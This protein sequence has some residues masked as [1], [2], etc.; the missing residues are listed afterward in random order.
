MRK[1]SISIFFLHIISIHL[2]LSTCLFSLAPLSPLR[3]DKDQKKQSSPKEQVSLKK[4]SPET[5]VESSTNWNHY[6]EELKASKSTKELQSFWSK[7]IAENNLKNLLENFIHTQTMDN[8]LD[9][10]FDSALNKIKILNLTLDYLFSSSIDKEYHEQI[11]ETISNS[12]ITLLDICKESYEARNYLSATQ[13]ALQYQKDI[14]EIYLKF[15]F[16]SKRPMTLLTDK[17]NELLRDFDQKAIDFL[18][19]KRTETFIQNLAENHSPKFIEEYMEIFSFL[20]YPYMTKK[21]RKS[22]KDKIILFDKLLINIFLKNPNASITLKS[23][24]TDKLSFIAQRYSQSKENQSTKQQKDKQGD[25]DRS[26]FDESIWS[27]L[28]SSYKSTDFL[29]TK[30]WSERDAFFSCVSHLERADFH[31]KEKPIANLQKPSL[32]TYSLKDLKELFDTRMCLSL[33]RSLLDR[34]A[35]PTIDDKKDISLWLKKIGTLQSLSDIINDQSTEAFTD[36]VQPS[37]TPNEKTEA[38]EIIQQSMSELSEYKSFYTSDPN[39]HSIETLLQAEEKISPAMFSFT[40][41]SD[42]ETDGEDIAKTSLSIENWLKVVLSSLE[43]IQNSS[44]THINNADRSSYFVLYNYLKNHDKFVTQE[45]P[46]SRLEDFYRIWTTTQTL[47]KSQKEA[48]KQKATGLKFLSKSSVEK[49]LK[50]MESNMIKTLEFFPVENTSTW[51]SFLN[52]N[53]LLQEKENVSENLKRAFRLK[54]KRML[55][56]SKNVLSS[57]LKKDLP[58]LLLAPKTDGSSITTALFFVQKCLSNQK[59]DI[60]RYLS[61]GLRESYQQGGW[62]NIYNLYLFKK[63]DLLLNPEERERL[64]IILTTISEIFYREAFPV[65]LESKTPI[66]FSP[67]LNVNDLLAS[68]D[69]LKQFFSLKNSEVEF[70]ALNLMYQFNSK[71]ALSLIIT[72]LVYYKEYIEKEEADFLKGKR[73]FTNKSFERHLE[74][75]FIFMVTIRKNAA[76]RK[77]FSRSDSLSQTLDINIG[78]LQKR[79][80]SIFSNSYFT[81]TQNERSYEE[82]ESRDENIPLFSAQ[83]FNDLYNDMIEFIQSIE[84][85]NNPNIYDILIVLDRQKYFQQILNHWQRDIF[86]S[87]NKDLLDRKKILDA[88]IQSMIKRYKNSLRRKNA[89]DSVSVIDKLGL[90]VDLENFNSSLNDANIALKIFLDTLNKRKT[91]SQNKLREYLNENF[92]IT[93][94]PIIKDSIEQDLSGTRIRWDQRSL[95][96]ETLTLLSKMYDE[97]N[98]TESVTEDSLTIEELLSDQN[99]FDSLNLEVLE[100]TLE[101]FLDIQKE[102]IPTVDSVDKTLANFYK[103]FEKINALDKN[104]ITPIDK[105][106]ALRILIDQR[107]RYIDSII[108]RIDQPLNIEGFLQNKWEQLDSLEFESLSSPLSDSSRM[109]HF[110]QETTI[111]DYFM[112]ST[113]YDPLA[114]QQGP[115]SINK[116]LT[117]SSSIHAF[118]SN[119][120]NVTYKISMIKLLALILNNIQ[121]LNLSPLSPN[122]TLPLIKS[123]A[124]TNLSAYMYKLNKDLENLQQ[125][126]SKL[127]TEDMPKVWQILSEISSVKNLFENITDS[128][129]VSTLDK[130]FKS[131]H[132]TLISQMKKQSTRSLESMFNQCL[133]Q[134]SLSPTP[135]IDP[136]YLFLQDFRKVISKRKS[137]FQ[138]SPNKNIIETFYKKYSS[139]IENFSKISKS[140]ISKPLHI[141]YLFCDILKKDLPANIRTLN[142][143][144]LEANYVSENAFS[145]LNSFS[146]DQTLA[147]INPFSFDQALTEYLKDLDIPST[148]SSDREK[149]VISRL[150]TLINLSYIVKDLD[151]SYKEKI[152]ATIIQLLSLESLP[153]MNLTKNPKTFKR[154][155]T[156]DQLINQFKVS[157]YIKL[158]L[159]YGLNF[160]GYKN[161]TNISKNLLN[162]NKLGEEFK[163]Y[164]LTNLYPSLIEPEL[165]DILPSLIQPELIGILYRAVENSD[166]FKILNLFKKYL[167]L[168]PTKLKTFKS[169]L[170][171]WI[172]SDPEFSNKT[173]EELTNFRKRIFNIFTDIST[174]LSSSTST[175]PIEITESEKAEAQQ[176]I[177]NTK[178]ATLSEEDIFS[179]GSWSDYASSEWDEFTTVNQGEENILQEVASDNKSIDD[180]PFQWEQDILQKSD[181]LDDRTYEEIDRTYEEIRSSLDIDNIE[182]D[183]IETI[184]ATFESSENDLLTGEGLVDGEPESYNQEKDPLYAPINKQNPLFVDMEQLSSSIYENYEDQGFESDTERNSEDNQ[185]QI[186]NDNDNWSDYSSMFGS[187]DSTETSDTQDITKRMRNFRKFLNDTSSQVDEDEKVSASQPKASST[188]LSNFTSSEASGNDQQEISNDNNNLSDSSGMFGSVDSADTS[189]SQDI[190]K[191]MSNFLNDTFVPVDEDEKVSAAAKSFFFSMLS[192][193]TSSEASG[194]LVS[195]DFRKPEDFS[196]LSN[197]SV[198]SSNTLQRYSTQQKAS[199]NDSGI[200]STSSNTSLPENSLTSQDD[201]SS[202][203]AYLQSSFVKASSSIIPAGSDHPYSEFSSYVQEPRLNLQP[204]IR[205]LLNIDQVPSE[206]DLKAVPEHF[207]ESLNINFSN[208]NLSVSDSLSEA[209]RALNEKYKQENKPLV[210]FYYHT[211]RDEPK[212]LMASPV[213]RKDN[214][215][216]ISE[217]FINFLIKNNSSYKSYLTSLIKERLYEMYHTE[218]ES[219]FTERGRLNQGFFNKFITKKMFSWLSLSQ[220]ELDKHSVFE[221]AWFEHIKAQENLPATT[222]YSSD[223]RIMKERFIKEK[224]QSKLRKLSIQ[225]SYK[226]TDFDTSMLNDTSFEFNEEKIRNVLET[227]ALEQKIDLST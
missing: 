37:L 154:Y 56:A 224:D 68:E 48:S 141:I 164:E 150:R 64:S 105:S 39:M 52:I 124:K 163:S 96:E 156:T 47:L 175:A 121:P 16:S 220:E 71:E 139:Y 152:A 227:I 74:K 157:L 69:F 54:E 13:R 17:V 136:M 174:E 192:N 215:I 40:S 208:S 49:V 180:S 151:S 53:K 7:V 21:M 55:Q 166:F 112:Q 183:N 191:R 70:F 184:D 116:I 109:W 57:F 199:F 117:A 176:L 12:M 140:D 34:F 213:M 185:Q 14:E 210:E 22:I 59:K 11:Q 133:R 186:S 18:N 145:S 108:P 173:D 128:Y 222:P 170:D 98:L 190:T 75:I 142:L 179:D 187:V 225:S 120:E 99:K 167:A 61:L 123:K 32:E 43:N 100:E 82:Q 147:T 221:A 89:E 129:D 15:T 63:N 106:K 171:T 67:S 122:L 29:K 206:K 226:D 45:S 193:F 77:F 218:Q 104:S 223:I 181:I 60:K 87:F 83:R 178:M 168:D 102:D 137:T 131:L 209:I 25:Q 119:I 86:Y 66:D 153:S 200:A 38:L 19:N 138:Q 65:T 26:E 30:S 6:F 113:S 107:N 9:N 10:A 23:L 90:Q 144:D 160:Q 72:K 78:N 158:G 169:N 211:D 110:L 95:R 3:V 196:K 146:L 189:D 202:A 33:L 2:F 194:K 132:K 149:T 134:L 165:I 216:I 172:T 28:I 91:K 50:K 212:P 27:E 80:P 195:S 4:P 62:S 182:N 114:V 201:Y 5:P 92:H 1:N 197:I 118:S 148:K 84:E 103:L 204:S 93:V 130:K 126:V 162:I 94:W 135:N 188:M 198:D 42:K 79:L 51:I 219:L 20:K 127:Q 31:S 111:K 161:I 97:S 36:T 8:N 41:D 203:Q 214:K 24:P 125:S 143:K 177:D 73:L 115:V 58:E 85:N 205:G 44:F 88:S 81:R 46:T 159:K 217:L 76:Y 35:H 207:K 101:K 155:K